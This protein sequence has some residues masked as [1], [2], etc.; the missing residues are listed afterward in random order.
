MQQ[1][2]KEDPKLR[3]RSPQTNLYCQYR[4]S[5][6]GGVIQKKF[7]IP[8]FFELEKER[9]R[10]H[11]WMQI[12]KSKRVEDIGHMEE[13]V[14]E[15]GRELSSVRDIEA[16]MKAQFEAN[17]AWLRGQLQERERISWHP[18]PVYL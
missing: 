4:F 13:K 14:K 15:V 18:W 5:E 6:G 11:R 16:M 3:E 7:F 1:E 8:L 10:T 2:T 9:E 17:N 12:A